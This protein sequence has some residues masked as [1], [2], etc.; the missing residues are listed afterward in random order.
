MG[1]SMMHYFGERL[2]ARSLRSGVV[3]PYFFYKL[4]SGLSRPDY[5]N[6]PSKI[7]RVVADKNPDAMVLIF[8]T[9]DAQSVTY[10]GR[11]IKYGTATWFS[12]YRKRVDAAMDAAAL[13]DPTR[14]VGRHAHHEGPRAKREDAGTERDL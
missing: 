4:S 12:L 11:V 1:D 14:V 7:R 5:Y 8:G 13:L 3:R 2:V 6:W 10:Q 9:N